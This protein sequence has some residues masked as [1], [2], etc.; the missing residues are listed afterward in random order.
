MLKFYLLSSMPSRK[1]RASAFQCSAGCKLLICYS[2]AYLLLQTSPWAKV[3]EGSKDQNHSFYSIDSKRRAFKKI[4]PSS[5]HFFWVL[6]YIENLWACKTI[7]VQEFSPKFW[8]S[9]QYQGVYWKSTA[10]IVKGIMIF[11]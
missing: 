7:W 10:L 8:K 9:L 2:R 11:F 5:T 6:G 1:N 3:T 4:R